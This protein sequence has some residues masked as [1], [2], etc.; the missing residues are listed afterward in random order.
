M[1]D[2]DEEHRRQRLAD[3]AKKLGGN[4]ALGRELGY[5]NGSFVGQMLNGS[6]P[7]AE[8]TVKKVQALKGFGNWFSRPADISGQSVTTEGAVN[9]YTD[10]GSKT[11]E[12]PVKVRFVAVNLTDTVLLL[13][14]FLE[15]MNAEQLE[16]AEVML[17][18]LLKKP[19]QR[20]QWAP[21][22]G[23][24][25]TAPTTSSGSEYVDRVIRRQKAEVFETQ[26][27]KLE[28]TKR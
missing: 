16:M 1:D 23:A 13:G 24:L 27:A 21:L 3:A 14:A 25:V 11:D 7:I 9:S 17:S 5:T 8:K 22:V 18:K 19:E 28:E 12:M 26:P 15:A 20:F 2:P 6:R 4:T 10:N